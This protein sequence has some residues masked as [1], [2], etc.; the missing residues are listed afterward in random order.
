M[1]LVVPPGF[2]QLAYRFSLTGDPEE[3]VTTIGAAYEGS[4]ENFLTARV[5]DFLDGWPTSQIIIGWTFKGI[6]GYF[7]Q[8]GGPPVV[9]H[10][11]Q[12]DAGLL[13]QS[14]PPQNV[15]V[16]VRKRTLLGGRK[17]RGRMYLPPFMMSEGSL[18]ANGV[19][20]SGMQ[21]EIQAET[22]LAFPGDVD[23]VLF[24]DD[25]SPAPHTPTPI[26]SLSVDQVV[27]TQ[28]RRLR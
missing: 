7:G 11:D 16:L 15:A 3:M 21:T 26:S 24:H 10:D 5:N 2:V 27:A 25:S 19:M 20:T 14:A 6:S 13:D 22:N 23:W 4:M 8:D 9:V 17:N 1:T 12:N 18:A 28:R